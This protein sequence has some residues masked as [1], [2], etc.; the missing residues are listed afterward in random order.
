MG[1]SEILCHCGKYYPI[2]TSYQNQTGRIECTKCGCAWQFMDVGQG[3]IDIR[4]VRDCRESMS[5][6]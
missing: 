4:K 1:K 3:R 5:Q 2:R 6:Y